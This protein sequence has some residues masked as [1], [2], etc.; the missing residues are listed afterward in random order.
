MRY[1][2][3]YSFEGSVRSRVLGGAPQKKVKQHIVEIGSYA[4][5]QDAFADAQ[6][7]VGN[8]GKVH[9]V[10]PADNGITLGIRE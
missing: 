5:W 7:M 1:A 9:R 10:F 2:M 4:K 3:R 8:T 6:R